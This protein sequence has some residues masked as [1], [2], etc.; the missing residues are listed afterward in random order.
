MLLTSSMVVDSSDQLSATGSLAALSIPRGMVAVSIPINRLTSVSFAP[1]PGDHVNVIAIM[2]LVDLDSDYQSLTPNRNAAVLGAGPGVVIGAG[3]A[4]NVSVDANTD[5]SK[6]TAQNIGAGPTSVIG[7]TQI[8]PLLEQTFY[9]VPSESQ[10]PRMV[11]QTLL[12]DAIVLGVGDF[13][14]ST[15][16]EEVAQPTAP[17]PPPVDEEN[18]D[19]TYY[20]DGSSDLEIEKPEPK[21]P[22]LITLIVTPQDAVTLNYLIYTGSQLTLALRSSGDDTR[23]QTEATTLDFLL[24]QY[25][26]PIPVRLPY[27][28][29]PRVDEILTPELVNDVQ[30]TPEP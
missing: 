22:D 6:V 18:G 19:V 30:P 13:P 4:E 11:S 10:R 1:R 20:E 23:V 12:Q 21:L 17:P 7:R 25:N 15:E 5:I 3:A 26:I 24:N 2:L 9:A 29:E 14:L 27:G 16:E 28:M 8:D